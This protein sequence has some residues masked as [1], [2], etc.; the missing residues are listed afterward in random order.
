MSCDAF[1]QAKR[2]GHWNGPRSPEKRVES[3]DA[4]LNTVLNP[5]PGQDLARTEAAARVPSKLG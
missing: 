4:H 5:S 1:N 3:K 2:H